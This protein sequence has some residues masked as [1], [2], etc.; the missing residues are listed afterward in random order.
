MSRLWSLAGRKRQHVLAVDHHDEAG[1]FAFQEFFDDDRLTGRA[2]LSVEHAVRARDRLVCGV[3]DH[4][5][6]A[7]RQAIGFDDERRVLSAHPRFVERFLRESGVR[8]RRDA[9]A[10]QERLRESLRSFESCSVLARPE[11]TQSRFLERIDD[12]DHERR[13]GSD[14]R[15]VDALLLGESDQFGDVIRSDVDIAHACF[16]RSACVTGRDEYFVDARRLRNFPRERVLATAGTD[17]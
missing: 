4:D 7:C 8:S 11:A 6:F 5:A 17:D 15:Q 16:E 13:F 3:A 1:F 9:V 10:L 12:A 14:D 2:E